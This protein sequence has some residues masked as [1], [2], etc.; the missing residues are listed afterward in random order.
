MKFQ[1][2]QFLR[3]QDFKDE[4]DYHAL[5]MMDHNRLLHTRGI[6]EGLMV[7]ASAKDANSVEV[8]AGSAIDFDGNQILLT[9]AET[10]DLSKAAAAKVILTVCY[11]EANAD[12]AKYNLDEGGFKGC[13]RTLEK[14]IFEAWPATS[15]TTDP[16]KLLLAIVERET[17]GKIKSVDTTPPAPQNRLMAGVKLSDVG[18][19]TLVDQSVTTE[20]IRDGAVIEIKLGASAVT[21]GKIKNDAVTRDKIKSGE[22]VAGKLATNAVVADNIAGD[23]VIEAKIKNDAVTR[24][25]IKG[26][27]VVAGKLATNAVVADNIAGDAVTEA[28]I[29]NDAVTRGKIKNGEVVAGKLATNAVVADNIAAEAVTYAKMKIYRQIST[30]TLQADSGMAFVRELAEEQL[31][32]PVVWAVY[33]ITDGTSVLNMPQ[34]ASGSKVQIFYHEQI[35]R[36]TATNTYER[37]LFVHNGSNKQ[38]Q[39]K[40]MYWRWD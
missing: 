3:A 14:P 20:K 15:P 40:V 38:L 5:K 34:S 39:V 25:K 27:E 32:R 26:G 19:A 22:V 37:V 4:Q 17:G 36:K 6:C 30:Q 18:S 23:A 9:E 7:K 13:T 21:E 31:N 10:V 24:N 33:N 29:K 28:K 35:T 16:N 8:S 2:R 11:G 1:E 12:D